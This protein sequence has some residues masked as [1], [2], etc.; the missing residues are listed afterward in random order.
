MF[1]I[2]CL[3][4]KSIFFLEKG[5]I[6]LKGP[7][8]TGEVS[9]E[10]LPHDCLNDDTNLTL[11]S[12]SL[13]H[14]PQKLQFIILSLLFNRSKSHGSGTTALSV[15]Q[16]Y[17]YRVYCLT[18]PTSLCSDNVH[19]LHISTMERIPRQRPHPRPEVNVMATHP[20]L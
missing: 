2:G 8:L 15:M 17:I 10:V 16:C 3:V 4:T 19:N 13:I 9:R 14:H 18:P 5:A 7:C 20:T 6:R 1:F 11:K 12:K